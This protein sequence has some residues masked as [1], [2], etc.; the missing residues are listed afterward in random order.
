MYK[1]QIYYDVYMCVSVISKGL[2]LNIEN[3]SD[4]YEI[5]EETIRK[6]SE[7]TRIVDK[8]KKENYKNNTLPN[9][10]GKMVLQSVRRSVCMFAVTQTW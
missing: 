1:L 7:E 2:I 6:P 4:M 9:E 5:I 3:Y 8:K 10:D